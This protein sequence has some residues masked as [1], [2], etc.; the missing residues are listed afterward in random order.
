MGT[1]LTKGGHTFPVPSQTGTGRFVVSN[2]YIQQAQPRSGTWHDNGHASPTRT[3]TTFVPRRCT[4]NA[5]HCACLLPRTIARKCKARW[6][7][8]SPAPCI[9]CHAKTVKYAGAHTCACTCACCPGL[10][11]ATGTASSLQL[12][13]GHGVHSTCSRHVEHVWRARK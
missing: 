11:C 8:T 13:E 7:Q 3:Q 9:N 5:Q 4:V 1:R 6:Q 10:R 2:R 12:C